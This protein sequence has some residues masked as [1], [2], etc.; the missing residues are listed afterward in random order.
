MAFQSLSPIEKVIEPLFFL[1]ALNLLEVV[2]SLY[3]YRTK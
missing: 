2:I 3:N 1:L